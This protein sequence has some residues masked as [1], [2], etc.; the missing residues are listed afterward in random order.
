MPVTTDIVRTFR[1]PRGVMREKLAG[2]P[3]EDRLIATLII[4]CFLNF[5]AQW[6][7]H[8]RAAALDPSIPL[9]AR[10]GG[11]LMAWLFIVPLAAYVVAAGTHVIARLVGGKGSWFGARLALFWALLAASPLWLLNGLVGGMIGPGP[12]LSAVGLVAFFTFA[13]FWGFGL[14]EAEF[15]ED[16][17]GK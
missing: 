8:A 7:V 16:G 15:G 1:S 13:A 17:A 4:A 10:L 11:A 14:W 9:E 12:G 3:R 2:G 5:V 6:P